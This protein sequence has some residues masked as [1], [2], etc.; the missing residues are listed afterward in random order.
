[1]PEPLEDRA[2]HEAAGDPGHDQRGCP[3]HQVPAQRRGAD[4]HRL[5]VDEVVTLVSEVGGADE[6]EAGDAQHEGEQGGHRQHVQQAA[7]ERLGR[8]P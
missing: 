1:M 2:E 3:Q 8:E 7:G 4:A 5:Q 6:H